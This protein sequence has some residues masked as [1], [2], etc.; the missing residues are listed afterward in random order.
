MTFLFRLDGFPLVFY[1]FFMKERSFGCSFLLYFVSLWDMMK[2]NTGEGF[3]MAKEKSTVSRSIYYY[4]AIM[5]HRDSKGNLQRSN[6]K[7]GSIISSVFSQIKKMQLDNDDDIMIKVKSGNKLFMIIDN[8]SENRIDFRIV[9]SRRDIIP[10]VEKDGKL[11]S[12][13]NYIDKNQNIAEITHGVYFKEYGVFGIEY[14]FNGAR[15]SAIPQYF[16]EQSNLIEYMQLS[17]ILNMDAYLKLNTKK[18]YSL[19]DITIR[20]NS[21]LHNK[22]ME[23]TSIF[24]VKEKFDEVETYEI[25]L[26]KRKTKKNGYKGFNL[27]MSYGLL[28]E[29]LKKDREDIEKFRVSQDKISENIDLLSDKFVNKVTFVKEKNRSIDSKNMYENI[30]SYFE[31]V[32]SENCEKVE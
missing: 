4:D 29:I 13:T 15:S 6:N 21:I 27:P 18:D 9:L 23:R 26:R 10:F 12:L 16:M 7:A 28:E 19:F 1:I 25:I 31:L 22:L 20:N 30:S 2:E 17:N 5:Y 8:D 32:V 24:A 11:E 14:N 3:K